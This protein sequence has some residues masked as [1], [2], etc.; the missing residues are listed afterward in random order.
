MWHLSEVEEWVVEICQCW[1]SGA[2]IG[3]SAQGR[4]AAQQRPVWL[5]VL[6][7]PPDLNNCVWLVSRKQ[8]LIRHHAWPLPFYLS[9]LPL[10]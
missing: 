8:M 1:E 6:K 2:Q 9:M 7:K 10:S 3:R 5:P 4:D